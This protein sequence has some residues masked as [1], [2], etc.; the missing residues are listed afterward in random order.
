MPHCWEDY[1]NFRQVKQKAYTLIESVDYAFCICFNQFPSI[2]PIMNPNV[3]HLYLI[4]FLF[5]KFS[6]FSQ[7][8]KNWN[9]KCHYT[10]QEMSTSS[11]F[12]FIKSIN[13]VKSFGIKSICL[14]VSNFLMLFETLLW[15]TFWRHVLE[16]SK[17]TNFSSSD[18]TSSK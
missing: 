4:S 6:F 11:N 9:L 13:S 12:L 1:W 15:V 2:S 18:R 5:F 8:G 14:L 7:V 3:N 17:I 10:S 16:N